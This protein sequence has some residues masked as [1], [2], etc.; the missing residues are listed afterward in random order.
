[1]KEKHEK[2]V[3]IMSVKEEEEEEEGGQYCFSGGN[4]EPMTSTA[5]KTYN[6]YN[7]LKSIANNQN[8]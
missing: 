6:R 1:L 5:G 2:Q 4:L 7:N 8:F 3:V